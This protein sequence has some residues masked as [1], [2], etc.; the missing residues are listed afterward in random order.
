MWDTGSD[1]E[2]AHW[3]ELMT[4]ASKQRGARAPVSDGVLQVDLLQR[5]GPPMLNAILITR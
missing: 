5:D 2:S 1:D 3:G 4:A